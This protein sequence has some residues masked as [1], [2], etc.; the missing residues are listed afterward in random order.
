MLARTRPPPEE[1]QPPADAQDGDAV[2]AGAGDEVAAGAGPEVAEVPGDEVAAEDGDAEAADAEAGDAEAGDDDVNHEVKG[3]EEVPAYAFASA[4]AAKADE[5]GEA[6]KVDPYMAAKIETLAQA[7][8]PAY[9]DEG[10]EQAE[11]SEG[12]AEGS[13]GTP[14]APAE[15]PGRALDAAAEAAADEDS[16]DD[17][18]GDWT[19]R[20]RKDSDPTRP[21]IVRWDAEELNSGRPRFQ[22]RVFFAG[23][24]VAPE[25]IFGDEEAADKYGIVVVQAPDEATGV[26]ENG[27]KV[28][29]LPAGWQIWGN[30]ALVH[31]WQSVH[32]E[33]RYIHE[34]C[35]VGDMNAE[36]PLFE[37][38][39]VL[40]EAK[41]KR[42]CQLGPM[43]TLPIL[44]GG[45]RVMDAS[46]RQRE[47]YHNPKAPDAPDHFGLEWYNEDGEECDRLTWPM[48]HI[49]PI[50]GTFVREKSL[51]ASPRLVLCN[52]VPLAMLAESLHYVLD[53]KHMCLVTDGPG[54]QLPERQWRAIGK[55]GVIL[56]GPHGKTTGR[57]CKEPHV[58]MP[59]GHRDKIFPPMKCL[60]DPHDHVLLYIGKS[61]R[62]KHKSGKRKAIAPVPAPHASK[63]KSRKP[64]AMGK[65]EPVG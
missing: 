38:C 21:E 28:L 11:N 30:K 39:L 57:A 53:V 36:T 1:A 25:R 64:E 20:V 42:D 14:G 23:N 7:Y 47:G 9:A 50:F 13:D 31:K 16:S 6:T 63:S 40:A 18:W 58:E 26:W 41:M 17:D 34:T 52:D 5:A 2:E 51:A 61:H 10:I 46:T 45:M 37:L 55:G 12:D 48:T 59:E 44:F 27:L 62:Q 54:A 35:A 24:S 8:A 15:D 65:A 43:K 3:E 29:G 56:I 49:G 19:A 22:W 4:E 32:V 60:R 33:H